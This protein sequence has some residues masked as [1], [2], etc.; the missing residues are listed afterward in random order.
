MI[1]QVDQAENKV[2]VRRAL[3]STADKTGLDLLI[4]GLVRLNPDLQIY[5]TGGTYT[6]VRTLLGEHH[7][8]TLKQVSE[9]TGQPEMQGGL[10]KTLDYRIYLGLLA[11][12]FNEAHARDLVN[13]GAKR[14]DLVVAN[15]YPFEQTVAKPGI[16]TEQ[17]R[18][19]IDIG[20]PC[21]LRAAAKNYLRVAALCNPEDYHG[22][23][24]SLQEQHGCTTLQDRYTLARKVFQHTAAY[25]TA[26]AA[27]LFRH[28]PDT[29]SS[30]YQLQEAPIR[31]AGERLKE[32]T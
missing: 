17:A 20:G 11:E 19:Q 7:S 28:S 4:Q 18:G 27:Y 26:I 25:D 32:E 12:S 16:T 8:H 22:F 2:Q 15:L 9:Y 21:M 31:T 30:A 29:V 5:S 10:V 13:T 23:L 3:I 14:F 1:N 24:V 6:H